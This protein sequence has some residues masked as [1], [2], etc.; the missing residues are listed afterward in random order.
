VVF[1]IFIDLLFGSYRLWPIEQSLPV[2]SIDKVHIFID[3]FEYVM[4]VALL[5]AAP[6][7][8]LLALVDMVFWCCESVFRTVKC[9]VINDAD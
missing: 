3:E 8:M 6:A 7:M 1:L 2:L 9:I 5:I 4:T